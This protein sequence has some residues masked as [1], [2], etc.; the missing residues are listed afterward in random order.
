LEGFF[1][2]CATMAHPVGQRGSMYLTTAQLKAGQPWL[3]PNDGAT[4]GGATVAIA[5]MVYTPYKQVFVI[6]YPAKCSAFS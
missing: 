1:A 2:D 3:L 5:F 6:R 4:Q